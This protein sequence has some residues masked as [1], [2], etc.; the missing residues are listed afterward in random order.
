MKIMQVLYNYLYLPFNMGHS[1]DIDPIG[2]RFVNWPIANSKYSNGIPQNI[3][4]KKY[5]IKNIPIIV[6]IQLLK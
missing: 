2:P 6:N 3:I 5:G 4:T 1:F